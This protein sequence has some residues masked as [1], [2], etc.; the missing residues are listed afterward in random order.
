MSKMNILKGFLVYLLLFIYLFIHSWLIMCFWS[1]NKKTLGGS[2]SNTQ[3]IPVLTNSFSI[4]KFLGAFLFF[5]MWEKKDNLSISF[6][7]YHSFFNMRM[8]HEMFQVFVKIGPSMKVKLLVKMCW[9]NERVELW[10]YQFR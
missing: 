7:T 6:N 2:F 8:V 5:C 3:V 10:I 9:T 1:G 4:S